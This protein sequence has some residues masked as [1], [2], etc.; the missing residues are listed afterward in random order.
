[1]NKLLFASL[2]SLACTSVL[3]QV[4]VTDPWVRATVPQQKATGAFM[5]LSSAKG[6]RLVDARSP[7][8]RAEIHEMAVQDHVMRM[9]QISGLDLPAGQSVA[10]KPGGYH[11]MFFDLKQP[12]KEGDVIP[13]TLVF[14]DK[15][16]KRETLELQVPAR[17]LNSAAK[18]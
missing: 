16:K 7:V 12:V 4:S 10:L 5:Q 1:M 17:A 9:R 15:D 8:A 13:L 14:E 6:T 11:I 18:H 2:L 3:A